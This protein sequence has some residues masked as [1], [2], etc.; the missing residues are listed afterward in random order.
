MPS[1]SDFKTAGKVIAVKDGA[2]IFN[3]RATRYQWELKTSTSYAGPLNIPVEALLRADARKV[4]TV[5]SGGN[6]VT[7]ITGPPRI[8]QGRV[9]YADDRQIVVQANAFFIIDLPP[10]DTA[11]DLDNGPIA[12]NT[13]VNVVALPGAIFE[14]VVAVVA[15]VPSGVLAAPAAS[16]AAA[17]PIAP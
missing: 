1:P 12:V 14:L 2:V 11:I 9:R 13:M 10:V 15:S 5:P 7:P 6:F 17:A 16:A 3:P 4:Y 8:V